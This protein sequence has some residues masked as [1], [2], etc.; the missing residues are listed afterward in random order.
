MYQKNWVEKIENDYYINYKT[1]VYDPVNVIHNL[2]DNE[3]PITKIWVRE[4][5]DVGLG[6]FGGYYS[7]EKFLLNYDSFDKSTIM[8]IVVYLNDGNSI[9][10]RKNG[11][12]LVAKEN[13]EITNYLKSDTLKL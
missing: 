4:D 9:S 3:V 5:A 11:V 13:I 8:D 7:V 12:T 2:L 6:F 1:N 10:I